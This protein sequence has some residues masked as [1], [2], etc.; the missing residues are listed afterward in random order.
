MYDHPIS[1]GLTQ[2]TIHQVLDELVIGEVW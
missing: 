2:D 1:V